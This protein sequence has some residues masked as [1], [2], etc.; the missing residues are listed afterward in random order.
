[1][2]V[3]QAPP[4]LPPPPP[5]PAKQVKTQVL[6]EKLAC[7]SG[8]ANEASSKGN[9]LSQKGNCGALQKPQGPGSCRDPSQVVLREPGFSLG[10]GGSRAARGVA[11]GQRMRTV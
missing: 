9:E 6:R 4:P 8:D 2:A 11:G 10:G 5:P 7:L 3:T 1:M